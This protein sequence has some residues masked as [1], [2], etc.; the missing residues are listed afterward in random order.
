MRQPDRRQ[1]LGSDLWRTRRRRHGPLH[2]GYPAAARADQ[3][4]LQ[5][6]R[7]RA[8]RAPRRAHGPRARHHGLAPF[9][10][11]RRHLPS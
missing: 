2:G 6:G 1:V 5:R 11:H 4:L 3:R 10:P 8:V 7:R 9:R